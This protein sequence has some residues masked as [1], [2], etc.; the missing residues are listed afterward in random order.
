MA[1]MIMCYFTAVAKI[2]AGAA[3]AIEFLGP[4]GVAV[5]SM[6]GWLRVELPSLAALGVI[7][8]S[9]DD[10]G[11]LFDPAGMLFALGGAA[12]WAA[13]MCS[14]AVSGVFFPSRMAFVSR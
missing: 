7:G 12:G 14:C 10:G 4:V 6:K 1:L 3:I 5:L 2:P 11:W 13:Y 8:I 9:F